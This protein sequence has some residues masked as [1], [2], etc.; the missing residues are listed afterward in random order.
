MSPKLLKVMERAKK[1]PKARFNSLAHLIDETALK[2]AFGRIHRDAAAG[3]DGVAKEE[4]E[5]NVE[6]NIQELHKRLKSGHYR[7]K[8]LRR[9]HIPKGKGKTR[10]IGIC[11]LEDKLVQSALCEVMGAVYEPIFRPCSFGFRPGRGAHDAIVA[12]N[13]MVSYEGIEWILEADIQSFFDSLDRKKLLEMLEGRVADGH[14]RC[15]IGKC[16]H[17]GVL[18]GGTFST[19]KAGT[20]QGSIISPLLGNVYLH[21][22]LDQWFEEIV[23]SRLAGPSRLIRYCDDF[24][25]GFATKARCRASHGSSPQENGSLWTRAAPGQDAHPAVRPTTVQRRARCSRYL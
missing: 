2:R 21:Y 3:V 8:P 6:A 23:K 9:V 15:L 5:Q 4:Y 22:V 7:H 24:V 1:D 11:T 19:P 10:P 18:D 16:L 13:R 20:V 14:L 17:V 12:L 25:I